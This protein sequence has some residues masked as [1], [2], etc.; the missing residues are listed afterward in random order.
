MGSSHVLTSQSV[1]E[2]HPDKVC[3]AIADRILD[4]CLAE[5][6]DSR[7]AC[8][9]L[10]KDRKVVL[11]GE[12]TTRAESD[13]EAIAREAVREIGY[14]R[15]E[16]PFHHLGVEIHD[17]ISRQSREIAGAVGLPGGARLELGAGDQGMMVGYATDETAELMPLPIVLAH[18]LSR[19]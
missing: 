18:R 1:T 7:V 10:C 11:A 15:S 12:I 16:E 6:P 4:A 8:E 5:D 2:G 17:W 19:G 13:R 3:D 14:I 9:V